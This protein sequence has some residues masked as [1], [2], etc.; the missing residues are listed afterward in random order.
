MAKSRIT[1]REFA[2]YMDE[3]ELR[4]ND[5]AK[6]VA[7]LLNRSI[8]TVQGY[9]SRGI[10]RNAMELLKAKLKEFRDEQTKK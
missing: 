7:E 3:Q 5:G 6:L 4:T 10:D 9:Y 2:R 8:N 1:G